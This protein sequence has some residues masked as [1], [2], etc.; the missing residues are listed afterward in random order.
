[1]LDHYCKKAVICQSPSSALVVPSQSSFPLSGMKTGSA[2]V[3]TT[4]KVAPMNDDVTPNI[5]ERQSWT[6]VTSDVV[7]N[8]CSHNTT[9]LPLTN[10]NFT[11]VIHF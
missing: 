5:T 8:M 2:V 6:G 10:I 11:A 9:V 7:M 3:P 4:D 1:M